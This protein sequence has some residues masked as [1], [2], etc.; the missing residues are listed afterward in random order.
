LLGGGEVKELQFR[1]PN[2]SIY[3]EFFERLNALYEEVRVM[4]KL[5]G[6]FIV[7]LMCICLTVSFSLAQTAKTAH[8]KLVTTWTPAINLIEADKYFAKLVGEISGGRLK[9]TV[10][11]AGE[12]VP[13]MEVFGAVSKGTFEIGGDWP[14]YWSG[15]NSAFDLLGSYPMGLCQ[16]D[17]INWY[18]HAGGRD[19][20]NWLYGKYNMVYFPHSVTPMESG[21]R[22]LVPIKTLADY[23]GKKLRMS[24]KAQ[25]YILKKIGA[26]QVMLAGGEI[27]QALQMKT[28][29]GGEF[30]SDSVDWGMGFGEV[31]KYNIGPGWHQPS[32]LLGVMI[33]KEAWNN[34]PNDLKK[35]IEIAAQASCSYMSSYY[36]HLNIEA[37]EKFKKAGTQTLKLSNE[38]LKVIEKYSWE[39]LLEEAKRN[40]DF[41]KVALSQ[42]QYLKDFRTTRNKQEPFGQGRNPFTIPNLPGLK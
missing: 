6:F 25:G 29:D 4:K 39:Y 17:Y 13:A 35:V 3:W 9:I 23:K 7:I 10:H 41:L 30:C 18:Y 36:E 28:I 21:I 38:D 40:P 11:P 14:N 33:N 8:W 1:F 22:S 27:Y 19:I 42:F 37:I 2:K 16:Y 24:G 31:T 12:L 5:I 34:L 20:F 15:K 26:S 32:S